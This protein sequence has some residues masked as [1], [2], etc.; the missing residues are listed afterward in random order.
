MAASSCVTKSLRGSLATIRYVRLHRLTVDTYSLQ[1][2]QEY[3][4]SGKSFVAHLTG[5]YSELETDGAPAANQAIQ[6]W[7][8]GPKVVE[9]SDDSSPRK[10][11]EMTIAYVHGATDAEEHRRVREWAR[12]TWNAWSGYHNLARHWINLATTPA[13]LS[14]LYRNYPFSAGAAGPCPAVQRRNHEQP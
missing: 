1:H 9:R 13:S 6:R 5:M 10:R 8:N 2:P 4:H 14:V 12:S 11:G 3:M 7:L